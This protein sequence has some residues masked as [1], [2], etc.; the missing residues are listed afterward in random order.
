MKKLK[1]KNG[2]AKI[3]K[4]T[5]ILNITSATDCPTK[6]LGLCKISKYC[7]ALQP[8]VRWTDKVT[9]VLKSRRMQTKIFDE[10]SSMDIA[11]QILK[12]AIRKRR[13]KIKYVRISECGDFRNQKD[14]NKISKIAELIKES[15]IRVYG[16]TARRDL[17]YSSISDNLILNGSYFMMHNRFVPVRQY[18]EGSIRCKGNCRICNLCKQKKGISIENKFHGV[19][20]KK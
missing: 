8:E 5:L 13:I 11:Y 3:G 14:V 15:G 17:S 12:K 18:S 10:L 20:F 7:Y 4:D 1:L 16:Y 2:N 6:K 19:G 9:G